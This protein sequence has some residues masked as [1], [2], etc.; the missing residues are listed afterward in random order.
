MQLIKKGF[1]SATVVVYAAE[2]RVSEAHQ[3]L[4]HNGIVLLL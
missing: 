4:A 1:L 3:T 2:H